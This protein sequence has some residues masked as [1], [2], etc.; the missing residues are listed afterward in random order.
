MP[1]SCQSPNIRLAI[2]VVSYNVRELLQRCLGAIEASLALSPA[3]DATVIVVD[4]ASADGSAQMVAEAYPWVRLHAE[5][6]NYGFAAGNNLAMRDLG[7]DPDNRRDDRP[8]L[9]LLLNPDAEPVGD[10][11]GQMAGFLCEHRE[12]GGAGARLRYPDGLF[13]HG[14]FGFPGL[15]QLAFDLFPIRPRRLAGTRL[16]GRYPRRAYESG[17][18]FRIDFALGAA[19]MVRKDAVDAV[20]LLDEDYFMYAEEVDWCWRMQRAGWPMWCVPAAEVIHHGGASAAQ[21]RVSSFVSLW[22]SRKRLYE[23]FYGPARRAAAAAMVRAGMAREIRLAES[24]LRQ[25][26]P[27]PN[28]AAERAIAARDVLRLFGGRP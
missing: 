16:N 18:P 25:S 9:I 27:A 17:V 22:R 12:A 14:A 2:V 26:D 5:T 24:A 13:Q 28:D 20:G 21:F 1:G 11:I 15:V 8:Q 19:L 3:L 7:F 10:A 23:K 6:E 4:N